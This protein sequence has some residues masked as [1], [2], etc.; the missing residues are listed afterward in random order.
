MS[1]I[2]L[3]EAYNNAASIA[4]LLDSYSNGR[5][6]A[7]DYTIAASRQGTVANEVK[8]EFRTVRVGA[9]VY[10]CAAIFDTYVIKW[11]QMADRQEELYEEAMF[12]QKMRTHKTYG[13]HFPE[14]YCFEFDGIYMLVQEK[15]NM[16]QTRT[17][18]KYHDAVERLATEL[19]IGD[20]H[21]GNFGWAGRK[22]REYPVFVDM[23]FRHEYI[24][25]PT[26]R[27]PRRSWEI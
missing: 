26:A 20:M 10:R 13:R 8:R 3:V 24:T 4:M 19:G 27:P 14:T 21:S 1:R 11:S 12:I 15:V 9:G 25:Y 7:W 17:L 5:R 22:G 18:R 6:R 2:N 23:D 16:K